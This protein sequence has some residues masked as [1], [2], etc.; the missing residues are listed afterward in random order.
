MTELAKL[1]NSFPND[2]IWGCATSSYQI[3][4]AWN[5]DG[6][7]ESIWDRFSH[8]PGKVTDGDTGDVAID[9][10]DLWESDIRIIKELGFGAYRFSISWPRVLPKGKGKIN[11]KGL[12]FYSKLIDGL[13]KLDITPFVTLY[14]WD[15]PQ[16][17]QDDGGW[18]NREITNA[19][20]EYA[21]VMSRALGDRVKFWATFNEPMVISQL[22]YLTGEHAPGHTDLNESLLAAHHVLLSHGKTIPIIKANV[23]DAQVG[24]VLNLNIYTP[25]SQSYLDRSA[26]RLEDGIANRWFLDPLAGRGY[27]GDVTTHYDLPLDYIADDDLEVICR[28]IDFLGINYYTRYIIRSSGGAAEENLPIT[29]SQNDLVTEMDWEVYPQGIYQILTRVQHNYDFPELYITENGAAFA[30]DPPE[31]G[32]VNDPLRIDYFREH[33]RTIRQAIEHGVNLK[34]YFAW[35][36]FDNFE[37]GH[38]YSK[39]FGIVYVDFDD[40]VRTLKDSALWF[41]EFLGQKI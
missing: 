2:F 33:I 34:G 17:L 37:W 15:L 39:R 5:Q 4:G 27:P 23:E 35:S 26:A 29:E 8:T 1:A 6:K 24:I 11:Q 31:D 7:G 3:E 9:H 25:A 36:L 18:T 41:Q 13:L 32:K 38:G 22:G 12:D 20:M 28:P 30:D 40:Q 14:H 21:D 19:F 10:Y 16:A